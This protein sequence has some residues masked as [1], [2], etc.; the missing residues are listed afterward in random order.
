MYNRQQHFDKTQH[1]MTNT[2]LYISDQFCYPPTASLYIQHQQQQ[3]QSYDDDST[4]QDSQEDCLI[5]DL[6]YQHHQLSQSFYSSQIHHLAPQVLS[7]I[8]GAI[9][10]APVVDSIDL[11]SNNSSDYST[12]HQQQQQQQHTTNNTFHQAAT[13]VMLPYIPDS[14]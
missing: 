9:Y 5:D 6:L 1:Q 10:I 7:D 4:N 14:Q 11:T 13:Q 8:P 3:Q 2:P 12:I